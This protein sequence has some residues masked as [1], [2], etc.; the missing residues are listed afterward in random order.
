MHRNTH[1]CAIT[2]QWRHTECDGVSN[3]QP[4]DCFSTVRSGEH[5][6]KHHSSASLAFVREAHQE[7]PTPLRASYAEMFPFDDVVMRTCSFI[8]R[9]RKINGI[10]ETWELWL[11]PIGQD[12]VQIDFIVLSQVLG[13][14]N[15]YQSSL[16]WISTRHFINQIPE[17][18]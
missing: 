12:L 2:L 16:L 9:P 11:V 17:R 14:L 4:H 7:F 6:R 1:M 13:F 3:H 5:R 8:H 18:T 15:W 10:L